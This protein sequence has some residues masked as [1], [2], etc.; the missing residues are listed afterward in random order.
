L[1]TAN[2]YRI[3][4]ANYANKQIIGY[5]PSFTIQGITPDAFEP[6]DSAS[7]SH[8]IALT[9]VAESHTFSYG[10]VDWINFSAQA[11]NIY[12]IETSGTLDTRLSL[13]GSDV[14]SSI[15]DD[16]TS[17]VDDN[18]RISWYCLT[19]GTYYVKA[20]SSEYGSYEIKASSYDSSTYRLNITAPAAGSS[21]SAGQT[22]TTTWTSGYNVGGTV[23]VFLYNGS[24][25]VSTLAVSQPNNGSFSW[26]VPSSLAA[27]STYRVK[28][29]SRVVTEVFG[30]SSNFAVQ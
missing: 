26:V 24:Q 21:Y 7:E 5:S 13:Y 8:T 11:G 15:A 18:A 22:V 1:A 17:G 14:S 2:T 9:G 4:I 19:A 16:D 6:D 12:V 10:D 25:V 27:A 30:Y 3:K 23:D 28:V 20:S 29:T